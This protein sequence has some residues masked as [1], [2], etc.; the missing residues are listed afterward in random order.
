MKINPLERPTFLTLWLE[1]LTECVRAGESYR[2]FP[3]W[4]GLFLV[5]GAVAQRFLSFK[6]YTDPAIGIPIYAGILTFNGLLLTLAWNAFAKIFEN[7][8]SPKFSTYLRENNIF[9]MYL[10]Q[11]SYVQ[12]AQIVA[13]VLSGTALLGLAVA[14]PISNLNEHLFIF[15]FANS[16]YA[17]KEA[18][19]AVTVL[20]DLIWYRLI[21]DSSME[22]H[23]AQKAVIPMRGSR[24]AS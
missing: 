24:S 3:Y 15:V 6:F 22:A 8:C 16:G 11:I 20:N 4:L 23:E 5:I 13:V 9:K 12:H 17:L 19:G 14:N 21:F 1:H 10:F 7:I 18:V 2:L